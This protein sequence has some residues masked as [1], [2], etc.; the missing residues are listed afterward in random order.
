MS[1][2][3]EG[4][5]VLFIT[6]KGKRYLLKVKEGK[7]FHSSEGYVDLGQVIGLP[8][9][10]RIQTNTGSIWVAAKPL[11]LDQVLNF[12]RVT[13]IVYPKDLGYVILMSGVR[14]GS[15]VVEG[16]TGAGVRTA[17]MD[18]LLSEQSLRIR[19]E[20][21]ELVRWVPRRMIIDMDQDK[22]KFPKEFLREAGK[23]NLLG[24][25]Y[26][27]EWGGRGLDWV[28]TAAV[29]EEIGTLGYIFACVF[30]VGAELVCDAIILHGTELQKEKYV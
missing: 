3:R 21:R 16:G 5:E 28:S 14:C 11:I 8:Y 9:G 6:G 7:V 29:M 22:I 1:V 19:D 4:D 26:P 24:C 17:M 20:A 27:V 23:R 25:R 2:I 30:G 18:Y 13:Q 12:P 10:S 15:R